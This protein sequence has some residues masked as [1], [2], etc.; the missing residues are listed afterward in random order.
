M[1]NNH[2]EHCYLFFNTH[3]DAVSEKGSVAKQVTQLKKGAFLILR[4]STQ[5]RLSL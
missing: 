3:V 4:S 2:Q 1:T 5:Q